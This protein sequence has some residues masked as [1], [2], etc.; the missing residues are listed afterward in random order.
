MTLTHSP[1]QAR[2][3]S[4]EAKLLN[5]LESMLDDMF[6]D[7]VSIRDLAARAGVAVGTVYR[8]FKDKDAMLPVLY[9]RYDG[10]LQAWSDSL[11]T[12]DALTRFTT[13]EQRLCH[14]VGSHIDFFSKHRGMMRTVHLY[15]RLKGDIGSEH[16]ALRRRSQYATLMAPVYELMPEPPGSEQQRVV[17]LV[18]ISSITEAILYADVSPAK[19]LAITRD[20]LLNGVTGVLASYL[21]T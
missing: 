14:L 6:F 2:S 13:V 10:E 15:G 5:A 3:R 21:S 12:E 17:I 4:T 9:Q 19:S 16:P 20:E 11:W 8:R 1:R 7:Q 18:M